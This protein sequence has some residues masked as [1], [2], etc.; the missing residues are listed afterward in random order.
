MQLPPELSDFVRGALNK[1][2]TRAQISSCLASSDWTPLEIETALEAWDYSATAGAVPRPQRATSAWEAL[3]Y[4]LLFAALGMVVANSLTLQ[5]GLITLWV[6][7][8][9]D[10]YSS[11]GL[12]QLRWSMAALIIF[13]P[14]FHWLHHKDARAT[15]TNPAQKH[16]TIRRWLSALAVFAAAMTL[17]CTAIYVIYRFLDG[18]MTARFIAKSGSVTLMACVVLLYFRQDRLTAG[19]WDTLAPNWL[20]TGIAALTLALSFWSVG[21]PAQ[22]RM[23]H[24]DSLRLSDLQQLQRDVAACMERTDTAPSELDLPEA[25]DPMTCA[26]N[27][28]QLTGYAAEITYERL[29]PRRFQLCTKVE[30]PQKLRLYN[31]T[32]QGDRLCIE[33]KL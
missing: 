5:H 7:E 16:G 10:S 1:G 4:A 17:L 15:G 18:D 14:V 22:G 12:G 25:L 3:F 33:R 28:H 30:D 6:P 32:L 20:V 29:G 2:M 27:P 24:R 26:R 8:H 31:G 19:H 21:G 9:G 13:A 11:Y 23:E